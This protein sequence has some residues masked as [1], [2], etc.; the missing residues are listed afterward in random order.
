MV[1]RVLD[2]QTISVRTI[3]ICAAGYPGSSTRF[4]HCNAP[5][6][7]D[8]RA[9]AERRTRSTRSSSVSGSRRKQRGIDASPHDENLTRFALLAR[10]V[11]APRPPDCPAVGPPAARRSGRARRAIDAGH[12]SIGHAEAPAQEGARGA[13]HRSQ[14]RAGRAGA[15]GGRARP[16]GGGWAE[17]DA[18]GQSEKHPGEASAARQAAARRRRR[19]P[20]PAPPPAEA[21]PAAPAGPPKGTATGLPLPRFAACAPTR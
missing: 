18:G 13:A 1:Q 7:A 10:R 17:A 4:W 12:S 14:G 11:N 5:K 15:Q 6:L 16:P 20:A 2:G 8:Q 3:V 19:R 9:K 21:K